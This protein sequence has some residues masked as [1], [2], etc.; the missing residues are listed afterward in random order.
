MIYARALPP[1]RREAE[2]IRKEMADAG[3]VCSVG[4]MG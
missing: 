3:R 2:R 4:P 1:L